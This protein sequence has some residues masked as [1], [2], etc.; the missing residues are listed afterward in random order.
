MPRRVR[1]SILVQFELNRFQGYRLR[2]FTL[3]NFSFC[4]IPFSITLLYAFHRYYSDAGPLSS[5]QS[6]AEEF[7]P[8]L[9]RN[10]SLVEIF[11]K[12][13]ISQFFPPTTNSTNRTFIN[14]PKFRKT[15]FLTSRTEFYLFIFFR[16]YK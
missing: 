2:F 1:T 10:N 12:K 11:W 4:L 7:S 16:G 13:E 5:G 15:Y 3:K 8:S 6:S 14:S 9:P